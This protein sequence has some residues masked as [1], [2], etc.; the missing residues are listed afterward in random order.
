MNSSSRAQDE[1]PTYDEEMLQS[2]EEEKIRELV[3]GLVN[4]ARNLELQVIAL[5]RQ[6]NQLTPPGQEEPFPEPHSDIYGSFDHFAA[7]EMFEDSFKPL[8]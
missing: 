7:Y 6:I 3:S 4:Y 2:I 1:E 5:R 8:R